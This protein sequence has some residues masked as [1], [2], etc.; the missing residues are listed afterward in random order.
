MAP[1]SAWQLKESKAA[2]QERILRQKVCQQD[3][4]VFGERVVREASLCSAIH[5]EHLDVAW[6]DARL[7]LVRGP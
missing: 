4:E 2:P 7:I 1:P 6:F 5:H 3:R